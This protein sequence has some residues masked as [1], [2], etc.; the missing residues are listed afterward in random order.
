MELEN[1]FSNP[2]SAASRFFVSSYDNGD[3]LRSSVHLSDPY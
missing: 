3:R 1:F 2:Y